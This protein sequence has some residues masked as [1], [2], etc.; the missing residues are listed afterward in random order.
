M[1]EEEVGE[2]CAC[3]TST[4]IYSGQENVE[5]VRGLVEVCTYTIATRIFDS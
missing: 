5:L 2:C 1:G 3:Y 4:A